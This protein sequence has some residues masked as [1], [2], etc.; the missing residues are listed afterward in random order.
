M[1]LFWKILGVYFLAWAVLLT[2]VLAVLFL[3][4][5]A[6]FIPRSPIS[7]NPPAAVGVQIATTHLRLGDETAFQQ[8]AD[9]WTRGEPPF[10]VNAQGQEILGRDVDPATLELA[11]SLA[12]DTLD[13]TPVRRLLTPTGKEYILFY[14]EG[15]GPEDR[16]PLRWLFHWPWL[17]ALFS[18]LAGLLLAT[19]LSA[20]WT[21]PI[22]ALKR[23]FEGFNEGDLHLE[24]SPQIKYRRDEIGDLARHFEQIASKL[25]GSIA[26]QRRLLHDISH[27][28]RSPLARLAV[29]VELARRRPGQTEAALE[30]IERECARLDRLIQEVLT[31][32]RLENEATQNGTQAQADEYFDLLELLRVIH[33]DVAFEAEAVGVEVELVIPERDELVMRGRAELLHRAVENV[34]RNALQHAVE[35]RRIEIQLEEPEAGPNEESRLRLCIGDDGRAVPAKE[36]D[37]LFEAFTHGKNSPGFGLG[38]AIARRAVAVHG[39]AIEALAREGGGV[40]VVIELPYQDGATG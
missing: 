40:E 5:R 13:L 37:S 3:D 25:A 27:E 10:V 28:L 23:S 2:A 18:T 22:A 26:S 4:L 12:Q 7:Q 1:K 24:L 36:L 33:D 20:A 14:P 35:A 16:S 29:A 15:R 38:L 32:A 21:R 9:L 8:L 34:V 39:G 31:L 19:G 11:R 17:L 30:R 6:E